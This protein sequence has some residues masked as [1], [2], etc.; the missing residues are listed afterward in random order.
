MAMSS[1]LVGAAAA[2][3]GWC[4][5]VATM[6]ATGGSYWEIFL[7]ATNLAEGDTLWQSGPKICWLDDLTAIRQRQI[8]YEVTLSLQRKRIIFRKVFMTS[9]VG[10]GHP[11]I[12]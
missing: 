8:D 3:F 6:I 11:L 1:V 2:I 9:I 7:G 5:V 10:V 12:P 4:L